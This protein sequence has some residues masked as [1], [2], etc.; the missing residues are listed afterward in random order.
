MAR[1]DSAI[2]EATAR[3]ISL[4]GTR[5]L[6]AT[7]DD[8]TEQHRLD[9]ERAAGVTAY[10][11]VTQLAVL[12]LG[13]QPVLK[14]IGSVLPSFVA[15]AGFRRPCCGTSSWGAPSPPTDISRRV[16]SAE[17]S[18]EASRC[19]TGSSCGLDPLARRPA[20]PCSWPRLATR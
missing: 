1:R 9:D 16:S 17:S 5:R 10:R 2:G 8:V 18:C 11:A 6:L 15:A 4:A 20:G 19:Q 3:F 13:G 14:S 7:L 12:L